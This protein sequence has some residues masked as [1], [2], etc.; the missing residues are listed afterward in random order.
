MRL[1]NEVSFNLVKIEKT[2]IYP[3]SVTI[4]NKTWKIQF[5]KES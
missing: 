5:P 1:Q 4:K 2:F 3:I